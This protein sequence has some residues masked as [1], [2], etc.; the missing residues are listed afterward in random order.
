MNYLEKLYLNHYISNVVQN[1]RKRD[2]WKKYSG[3]FLDSINYLI[4]HLGREWDYLEAVEKDGNKYELGK[5]PGVLFY[6]PYVRTDYIQF[7]IV[8]KEDF[9]EREMLDILKKKYISHDAVILDIGANIENHTVFFAKK[10]NDKHIYAFEPISET[11]QILLK[12]I[13]LNSLEDI[14]SVYNF[15]VGNGRD[16]K[17]KIIKS[18]PTNIG[19]THLSNDVN[20]NIEVKGLDELCFD[21][22]IDFIKIDVEGFEIEVLRGAKQLMFRDAPTIFIEAFQKNYESV[23]A[24]LES[25]GYRQVEA[26]PDSNYVFVSKIS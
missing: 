20:G 3:L 2:G 5:E 9:Y 10:C 7:L 11:C 17:A 13:E 22:H 18:D 23:K 26:L 25:C 21:H 6:L 1:Y 4:H 12:N 16:H 19:G 14:V 24:L 15:A 8:A